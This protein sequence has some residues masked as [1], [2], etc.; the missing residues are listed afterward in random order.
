M[1]PVLDTVGNPITLLIER[2]A[3]LCI[4]LLFIGAIYTGIKRN[5]EDDS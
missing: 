1:E 4:G 5:E 2:I 3:Y